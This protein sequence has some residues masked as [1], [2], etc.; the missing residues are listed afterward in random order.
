MSRPLRVWSVAVVAALSA[1]SLLGTE[2]RLYAI[3]PG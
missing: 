1:L 2:Q 3:A